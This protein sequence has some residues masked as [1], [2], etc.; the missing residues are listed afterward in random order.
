[1]ACPQRRP[2]QIGT[3]FQIGR[4]GEVVLMGLGGWWLRFPRQK[5]RGRSARMAWK[6]LQNGL[7]LLPICNNSL[8]AEF[9]PGTTDVSGG[10]WGVIRQRAE[11]DEGFRRKR[12]V[13]RQ[14]AEADKGFRRKTG[15]DSVKGRSRRGLFG[16]NWP[17]VDV[18]AAGAEEERLARRLNLSEIAL[19]LSSEPKSINMIRTCGRI[20]LT[21]L[22]M[23]VLSSLTLGAQ[24]RKPQSNPS[25]HHL[26][27]DPAIAQSSPYKTAKNYGKTIAVFGGSLSVNGESDVAK[28]MWA[29]LLGATVDTYGVGGAGF[30]SLQGYTIQR[31]VDTAG[32]YDIYV[33]WAS[34]NDFNGGRECGTWRDYTSADGFDESKLT[35]QCGGINYCIKKLMEKNPYAEIYFFTGFRFFGNE[36][37]HNPF[38]EKTNAT[39]LNFAAYVQAQ[40]DCCAHYGIPVL[41]QFNIQGI[42][43]FNASLY[44][45]PDKL[46]L[47]EEGYRRLG[48]AQVDFLSNGR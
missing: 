48:P 5:G 46:H 42:N 1:M 31:Q 47:T 2:G 14:R 16:G 11:A 33:L 19:I 24:S 15:F 23:A 32:V 4:R 41:D 26:T 38:S 36:A 28:Q 17:L 7:P 18:N 27:P 20:I 8:S 3:L 6:G 37:G 10:N 35:T 22:T 9:A 44:Y 39:G 13:I 40:K 43:E 21:A 25:A 29:D 45:K 12:D 30:S 34:T